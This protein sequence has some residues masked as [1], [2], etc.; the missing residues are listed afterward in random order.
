ML[1]LPDFK[2]KKIVFMANDNEE[3]HELKFK[4]SNIALYKDGTC[5]NQ[6]SCH[7]VLSLFIIGNTTISSGLIKN[8]KEFG[9][10]IFLLTNSFETYAEIM[11]E[12]EGNY[13]LRQIQYTQTKQSELAAARKIV[14]NA[15]INQHAILKNY[16][17]I[18]PDQKSLKAIIQATTLDELLGL[19]GSNANKFFQTLLVDIG[20]R[21]RAPR[22]KEDIPNLLLDIGFTFLFNYV[23]SLLR[24]FGFDTYKGVYHQLYFQRKSLSCDLMEPIRPIIIR[25]LLKSYNLGQISEKDFEFNQGSYALKT[26]ARRKYVDI[27]FRIIMENK[28]KI[29]TYILNYYRH[30]LY[31]ERYPFPTFTLE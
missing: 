25:Q 2:E 16:K 12:A 26:K 14:E 9:I 20:W 21:R 15:V 10:S 3:F 13:K 24:L 18:V 29:Y 1:T 31:P 5:V 4:N 8:A 11:S 7:L 6:I 27:W 23:D 17:K 22:T 30:I 28:E 19:E